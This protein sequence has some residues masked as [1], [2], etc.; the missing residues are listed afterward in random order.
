MSSLVI[1]SHN[2]IPA[3]FLLTQVIPA[4]HPIY[5]YLIPAYMTPIHNIPAQ[6]ILSL[7]IVYL[8]LFLYR[9]SHITP[10]PTPQDSH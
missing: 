5:F 1:L 6:I 4:A 3:N 7:K 10:P 9:F 8:K 2:F